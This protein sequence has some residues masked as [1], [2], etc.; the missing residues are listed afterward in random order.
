MSK[1]FVT[2]FQDSPVNAETS[3]LTKQESFPTFYPIKP[4]SSQ[5]NHTGTEIIGG[6]KRQG[7][8]SGVLAICTE[9]GYFAILDNSVH[10]NKHTAKTRSQHQ[11][12]AMSKVDV[13][14]NGDEEVILCASN[15][16]TYVIDKLRDIVSFEFSENVAAFCAGNYATD[17]N[18]STP[19]FCYVTF[20]GRIFLY[21]D[22]HIDTMK[23]KCVHEA[24][25]NKIQQKPELKYLLDA[26]RLP[27]GEI[28]HNK[29]QNLV[30]SLW[31]EKT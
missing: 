22:V 3:S 5:L 1:I 29:V 9:D 6:I 15:G 30:K 24:L 28:D 14:R 31:S 4:K 27:N 17:T 18:A 19:C 25:I 13:T 20:S 12:L 11:W 7:N 8:T 21:Y 26:L 10:C 2:T 23:V 16:V